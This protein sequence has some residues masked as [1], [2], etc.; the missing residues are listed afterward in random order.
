MADRNPNNANDDF[1]QQILDMDLGIDPTELH[2]ALNQDIN[3]IPAPAPWGLDRMTATF[4][5]IVRLLEIGE[6]QLGQNLQVRVIE[7][8]TLARQIQQPETIDTNFLEFYTTNL[9]ALLD[10]EDPNMYALNA[11]LIAR[12]TNFNQAIL[13]DTLAD[14][15]TAM[16]LN[17]FMVLI[18]PIAL[19][20]DTIPVFNIFSDAK[21]LPELHTDYNISD[22]DFSPAAFNY[23]IALCLIGKLGESSLEI[24]IDLSL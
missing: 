13:D 1:E 21:A 17:V 19:A 20:K 9:L 12:E 23:G 3:D 24:S 2:A 11:V 14:G 22:F 7:L 10:T 6:A 15:T 16:N 5:Q 18:D 4:E 8:A